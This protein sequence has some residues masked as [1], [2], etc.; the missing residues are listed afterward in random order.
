MVYKH[1]NHLKKFEIVIRT[2]QQTIKD[3]KKT[4]LL[5]VL[6]SESF[7]PIVSWTQLD[8]LSLVFREPRFR[9]SGKAFTF[10]ASPKDFLAF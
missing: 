7:G 3:L 2:L 4:H 1:I 8:I 10:Q 6:S 9:V 5:I